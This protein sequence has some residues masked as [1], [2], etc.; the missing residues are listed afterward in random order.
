MTG[1]DF[2][3]TPFGT[4][5]FFVTEWT[6]GE[7]IVLEA[8]P[9]FRDEVGASGLIFRITPSRE[10]S[11]LLM[12]SGEVEAIWDLIEASIPEFEG[13]PDVTL[14]TTP[15]SNVEDLGLNLAQRGEPT[16]RAEAADEG[17]DDGRV[18]AIR[19]LGSL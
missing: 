14:W 13:N 18:G 10:A 19:G 17:A 11:V 1:A 4:G 9:N 6:S 8:N 7:S 2:N 5:P 12:K 15:S 3:R 16:D